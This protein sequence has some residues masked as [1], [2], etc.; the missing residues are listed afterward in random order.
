MSQGDMKDV[1]GKDR[2]PL[3]VQEEKIAGERA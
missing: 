2:E 3:M 1:V